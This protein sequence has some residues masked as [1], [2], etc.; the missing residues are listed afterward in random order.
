LLAACASSV[1]TSDASSDARDQTPQPDVVGS[2]DA[3]D[4]VTSADVPVP[5]APPDAPPS[6]SFAGAHGVGISLTGPMG[7]PSDC[8]GVRPPGPGTTPMIIDRIATVVSASDDAMGTHVSL[9]YCSPAADCVPLIGSLTIAAPDFS[10]AAGPNA[11]RPGQFVEIRSRA[12]WSWGCTMQVEVTNAPTWDGAMNTIRS[13]H[14]LLAAAANGEGT[15]L[16]NPM[17]SVDRRSIGCIMTGS[18]CGGGPPELFALAFQGACDAC[19][20]PTDP[21]VVYQGTSGTLMINSLSY[22]A[23]NHE[24]YNS[25]ACDDYWDYAWTVRELWLE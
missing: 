17:F 2:V 14:A 24:S 18:G 15:A 3:V 8:S 25:G 12:T 9:D 20:R 1:N 5:D 21:V 10:L 6:C 16:P 22:E 4:V 19:L 23:R 13:D 11:L 7:V